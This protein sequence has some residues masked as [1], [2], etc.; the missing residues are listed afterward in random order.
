VRRSRPELD[1]AAVVGHHDRDGGA[2]VARPRPVGLEGR[3]DLAGVRGGEGVDAGE[4][5]AAASS[6][7]LSCRPWL[8][9]GQ[10]GPPCV[11][12]ATQLVMIS[13]GDRAVD[14]DLPRRWL[15]NGLTV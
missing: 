4:K 7:A 5:G 11:A 13:F 6:V 14:R 10:V 15:R 3:A 9:G 8:P 12:E 2:V 1:A